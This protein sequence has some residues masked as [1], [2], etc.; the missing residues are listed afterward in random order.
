M[1]EPQPYRDVDRRHP[2]ISH[3]ELRRQLI[4]ADEERY[5]LHNEL[6]A[7][8]APDSRGWSAW[9]QR[10]RRIAVGI[11][12]VVMTGLAGGLAWQMCPSAARADD[13]PSVRIVTREV[14][15]QVVVTD[16]A[17]MRPVNKAA[18]D[19]KGTRILRVSARPRARATLAAKKAPVHAG[20]VA[21]RVDPTPRRAVVPRPLSPGEFGRPRF[22]AY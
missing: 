13:R 2:H 6:R 4:A 12:T 11:G 15:P 16:R 10:R 7:P 14:A 20:V 18:S 9:P 17:V 8:R 19:A 1:T 5:R 3:E 21:R 22:A